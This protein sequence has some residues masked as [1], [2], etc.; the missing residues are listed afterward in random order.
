[1]VVCTLC[2]CYPRIR[3]GRPPDWYERLA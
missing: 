2:S 1:M 3:L